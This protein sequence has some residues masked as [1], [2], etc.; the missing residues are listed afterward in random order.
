MCELSQHTSLA[1][2]PD[3][4][5]APICRCSRPW[6]AHLTQLCLFKENTFQEKRIFFIGPVVSV[7]LA[8]WEPVFSWCFAPPWSGLDWGGGRAVW[9]MPSCLSH[10]SNFQQSSSRQT[11]PA[12][13]PYGAG[14]SAGPREAAGHI[15]HR[16]QGLYPKQV[17]NSG[18][19]PL[20][21]PAE[22]GPGHGHASR[23]PRQACQLQGQGCHWQFQS[24]LRTRRGGL[25]AGFSTCCFSPLPT[26]PQP[27]CWPTLCGLGAC[28][29]SGSE[30]G[31]PV[32]AP[33]PLTHSF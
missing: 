1:E 19:H 24:E 13:A 23:P 32:S 25:G 12:D 4:F 5:S 2:L 3:C 31:L 28:I 14:G 7:R 29:V 26:P 15:R 33:Q 30:Y 11:E 22:A 16:H 6:A 10:S 17:P 20:Q 27:F 8:D 9:V 18:C 21:V